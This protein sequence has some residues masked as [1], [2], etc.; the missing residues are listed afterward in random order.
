VVIFCVCNLGRLDVSQATLELLQGVL[1]PFFFSA[2]L[3]NLLSWLP[4]YVVVA[5]ADHDINNE[6]SK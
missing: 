5:V 3:N 4:L 2:S 6:I 1:I